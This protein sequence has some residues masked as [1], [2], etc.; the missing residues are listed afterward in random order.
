MP[1]TPPPAAPCLECEIA[2]GRVRPPGG[3][4]WRRDGL[5]LHAVAA[6]TPVRGWLVVAPERHVRAVYDLDEGEAARLAE[7]ARRV[8]RLQREVLGAAHAYHVAIGEVLLHA[9]VHL[10][11][12]YADT[13]ERLRGPQVFLAGPADAIPEAEAAAAARVVGS[14]LA[15]DGLRG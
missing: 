5:V 15:V 12:R 6:P 10:I 7:V 2:S 9:H 8:M 3:V 14:A 11:P 4:L 13:P 1:P